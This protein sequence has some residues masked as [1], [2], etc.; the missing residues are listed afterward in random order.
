MTVAAAGAARAAGA[1][2][3]ARGAGAAGGGGSVTGRDLL[4]GG[5]GSLMGRKGKS[6]RKKRSPATRALIAE[7]LLCTIV[8]ALSPLGVPEED[9]PSPGQWARRGSAIVGVFLLLGLISAA[10]PRAG[11]AA[12][13]F[14]GLVTLVLVIDQKSVFV[15]IARA[16]NRQDT[17]SDLGEGVADVITSP[18]ATVGG[19]TA[20]TTR[21]AGAGAT[22]GGAA[23]SAAGIARILGRRP[24]AYRR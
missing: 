12:A 14:G 10:G 5:T 22:V 13:M 23:A 6:K 15:A 7:F 11:K 21:P 1:G 17:G 9:E 4:S 16:V 24:T 18:G 19:A 8:L 2:A 3:G 20:S